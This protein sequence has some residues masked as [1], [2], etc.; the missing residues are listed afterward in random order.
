MR[1][2]TA[3]RLLIAES[4]QAP[5][6]GLRSLVL[7]L[8]VALRGSVERLRFVVASAAD[9]SQWR[10][11]SIGVGGLGVGDSVRAVFEPFPDAAGANFLLGVFALAD[12]AEAPNEPDLS[13]LRELA[14]GRDPIV[15]ECAWGASR[16]AE[17]SLIFDQHGMA[18]LRERTSS[19]AASRM[20]H[21]IDAYW[22]DAYGIYLRGWAHAYEH[23]VRALRVES[24]GRSVTVS[25]FSERADLL[26]HYPAHDHVRHSG[27][28][29]YLA[30]P[31]GQPV[32]L[33]VETDSG[34]VGSLL[35]LP[36]G[37]IPAWPSSA[38]DPL[39]RSNMWRKFATLI[40]S[41]GGLVLQI[42]ARTIPA[43]ED[44]RPVWNSN[45]LLESLVIGFD[46]HPGPGVTVVGDAHQ[47]S[48][49]VRASALGGVFSSAVLEHLQA[50]WLVAAEV[51]RALKIGGFSYH[52]VP[53]AWPA[54]AQPN[55]FWRFTD[56]GLR[57]LFGPETGFEVLDVGLSGPAA[58]HPAPEWR[59]EFLD[60]PTVPAYACAEILVRK[61]R[62]LEAGAVAWP[63]DARASEARS[64]RYPVEA[65][66]PP[67]TPS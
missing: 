67:T 61:V 1:T 23:R 55:D 44:G 5:G 29:A 49:Y 7:P 9:A 35:E 51:N 13:A 11:G 65:L 36:E 59:R 47:L 62:D 39:E 45:E 8:D 63:L 12:L 27:F 57:T 28:A 43:A 48:R 64:R 15:L 3:A 18:V 20:E 21:W 38:A 37:P 14:R 66:R 58:I 50:P 54:H 41:A 46:I 34:V 19:G 26:Q 2:Q 24:A 52:Q 56:E 60:M 33:E 22:R 6:S 32:R 30:C 25:V 16:A 53:A 42:G 40:N 17:P 4:F 10:C 31:A